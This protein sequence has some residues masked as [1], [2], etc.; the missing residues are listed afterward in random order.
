MSPTTRKAEP[1]VKIGTISAAV[2]AVLY[3]LVVFGVPLTDEQQT[4]ILAVVT[5]VGPLVAGV[6]IR[7]YVTP[8]RSGRRADLNLDGDDNPDTYDA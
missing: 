3:L 1:A 7:R 6:V 8:V 4:A 5:V 2:A